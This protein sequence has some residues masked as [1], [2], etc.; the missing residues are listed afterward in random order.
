MDQ[1]QSSA[2]TK[3]DMCHQGHSV[4]GDTHTHAHTH[5][6]GSWLAEQRE[7]VCEIGRASCRERG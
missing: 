3:D 4:N 2:V 6:E 1:P 7:D 5:T